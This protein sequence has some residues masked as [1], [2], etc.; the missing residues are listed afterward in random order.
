MLP[1][2]FCPVPL[3]DVPH[4][5][6]WD[7]PDTVVRH[8]QVRRLQPG[9]IIVLWDGLGGQY[10]AQIEQMGR[11]TVQVSLEAHEALERELPLS[12]HWA[13]GCL[14]SER[15]DF[16]IEKASELGVQGLW[17]LYT[18]YSSGPWSA[19]LA[20]K[21]QMQW[22]AQAISACTQC[23]RNRMPQV[24]TPRGLTQAWS[25]LSANGWAIYHLSL[26]SDALPLA[27][28][29]QEPAGPHTK[30]DQNLRPSLWLSGPEGGFSP[31]EESFL[32]AHGSKPVS[33]GARVLRAETAPLVV[34]SVYGASFL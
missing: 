15:M 28:L 12:I 27:Q 14:A 18:E 11:H 3:Q 21:K 31:E 13:M 29:R 5:A 26:R 4:H 32:H 30:T 17:P 1:R 7:L 20:Q 19:T 8:V 24:Q 33:L 10:T 9:Q 34:L 22:Q 23:G 6:A 16:F 2:F 25:N